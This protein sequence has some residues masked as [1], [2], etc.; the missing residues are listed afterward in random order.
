MIRIVFYRQGEVYY[1]FEETGHSGFD[2]AA[3][4][5]LRIGATTYTW[6]GNFLIK[7]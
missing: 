5:E 1:G 3:T 4:H 2:E 6:T 7:Q